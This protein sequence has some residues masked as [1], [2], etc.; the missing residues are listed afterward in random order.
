MGLGRRI[1]LAKFV[2]LGDPPVILQSAQ[3]IDFTVCRPIAHPLR[4]SRKR[5]NL[6]CPHVC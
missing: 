6:F 2:F 5:C 4:V 1:V 3:R